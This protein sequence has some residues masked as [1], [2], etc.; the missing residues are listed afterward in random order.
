VRL[1]IFAVLAAIALTTSCTR[2]STQTS[3]THAGNPWTKH[4]ILRVAAYDEPDNL[5]PMIGNQQAEVD[6]SLL[7]GA[8]LYRFNDK[9]QWVPELA[10]EVPTL[11]NGGISADGLRF[12]YHLRNGVK[13]Q[14]GAPFT[15]DDVIFSWQQVMNPRNNVTSRG[16]YDDITR[17]EKT[18]DDSIVVHL[19]KPYAPFLS[20]FFSMGGTPMCILPKHLLAQ[21]AD[22]NQVPYNNHPIGTGP[23]K[24]ESYEKGSMITLVANPSYFRGPPKLQ[25]IYWHFLP[26]TN[27]LMT[28]IR[29]HEIDAWFASITQY[30]PSLQH[31]PGVKLYYTPLTAYSML[32]FN[33]TRPM[34]SDKIVRQA[35][36]YGLDRV[37]IRD[38]V[39]HGVRPLQYT[40]Q[41]SFLWAYNPNAKHYDY[42]PARA[43]AMLEGDGWKLASDGYRYKNGQRLTVQIVTI[44]GGSG[45]DNAI[46]QQ[47]WQH[48]GVETP[49]KIVAGPLYFAS[50]GAGGVIQRGHF[51]VGYFGWFNGADPDD[52]LLWMCDQMPP[53]GQNAYRFCNRELDAQEHIALGSYDQETRKRAYFKIQDI[54]TEEEP[55]IFMLHQKRVGTLNS[56]FKNYKPSHA[57][58]TLWNPWE[59][60]I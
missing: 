2:I 21:Y 44:P 32:G 58:S 18:G 56:D 8:Y 10:T 24:V 45:G 13:W 12:T 28:Q 60:E 16:G 20:A 15:A 55:V 9:D 38:K 37:S 27:T 46:I 43:S 3:V 23:F 50:Y 19:R 33:V 29:T 5:N 22:I 47:S 52:S 4:G 39:Y 57:V 42:D 59:W 17:I 41:P 53:Y 54:L 51:D 34:L 48:I 36:A 26:D 1:H 31:I 35:L 6:L 14:D 40:D 7:W 11:A 30:V 49:I 25:K